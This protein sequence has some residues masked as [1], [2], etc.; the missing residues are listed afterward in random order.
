MPHIKFSRIA[1]WNFA[2]VF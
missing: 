2:A 1:R